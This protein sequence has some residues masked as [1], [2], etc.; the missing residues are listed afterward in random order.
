MQGQL[1][2]ANCSIAQRAALAAVTGDIG[3]TRKMVEEYRKRREVVYTLLKE[4]PG[5]R[6]NYP[7]GAFY[8]F[9]DVSSFYGKSV[10]A[11]TI[12]NGEDLCMYL[13]EKAHVSLVT[14]DAFGEPNCIRLSYAA[15]ESELKEAL[16]RIRA[17][18][19]ELR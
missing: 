15:S 17:S 6:S 11:A 3:P 9:P 5:I 18:L 1:T 7:Q 13:L 12:R 8:F 4:I 16:E 14:G 19:A 2:S 10:G